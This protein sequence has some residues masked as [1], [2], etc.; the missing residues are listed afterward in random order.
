MNLKYYK[1]LEY[2]KHYL[3]FF[4]KKYQD[5]FVE[6]N[7]KY[8][9]WN[10]NHIHYDFRYNDSNEV[11]VILLH[12]AGGNGR[13]LSLLGNFIFEDGCN[14]FA[15]DNL[16]YGLTELKN[17]NFEYKDWVEMVSDFTNHILE[18]YKKPVVLLGM[19][20]GG[21]LAYQVAAMNNKISG[22]IVS[23][24]VDPRKQEVIRCISKN[25]FLGRFG[26]NLISK[27][28]SPLDKLQLPVKWLCKMNLMSRNI[29]FAKLFMNDKLAGGTKMSMKYLR[30]FVSYE[31]AIEFDHF[32]SCPILLIHPEL[33]E[34]TPFELSKHTFDKIKGNKESYLLKNCGHAPIEEPGLTD[35]KNYI[36]SFIRNLVD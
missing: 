16:G 13:I 5:I 8:W 18:K 9:E 32:D 21:M 15:P 35:M 26:V 12:G 2:W 34:W 36:K 31:P 27:L 29:E 11:N 28:N 17:N 1:D 33:D 30:T 3:N 23:T 4:P 10:S 20:I 6:P 19:S 24:L 14:Y 25:K 7:E 22:I